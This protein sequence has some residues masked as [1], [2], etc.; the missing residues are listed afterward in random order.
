MNMKLMDDDDDD[1]DG[2][3]DVD[4][5]K[6]LSFFI[7]KSNNMEI[8]ISSFTV[9]IENVQILVNLNIDHQYIWL[10]KYSIVKT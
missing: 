6:G 2:F 1:D 3:D 4:D 7:E 5:E 9:S 8:Y 10:K